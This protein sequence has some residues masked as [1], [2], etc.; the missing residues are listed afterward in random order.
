MLNLQNDVESL[1]EL[2]EKKQRVVLYGAGASARL[3]LKSYRDIFP[4]NSLEFIIDGSQ[5][6]DG[7]YCVVDDD[8]KIRIISLKHFCD[9]YSG[10]TELFT[11]LLTPYYSLFII[12][13]LDRLEALDG[14]EAYV[15]SFIVNR[16]PP[17][18]FSFKCLDKPVIPRILHYFWL[19]GSRMPQE[20]EKHMESWRR[21]CPDYEIMR[22]DESNYDFSKYRYAREALESRQY[23]YATDVARKD[24]L[25]RYGGI[26]FD[27]DVELLR[28]V[29]DLLYQEAFIGIDDGGQLNSGS[30][31]GCVKHSRIVGEM[32]EL[33]R[34]KA[35]INED[36]SFNLHYNTLYETEL[37]I[38]KGY[39]IKNEYQRI[40]G[41][42]CFPREVF[43][44]RGTVGVY[45][46]YT[47]R[48]VSDHK[49]NPY[50]Q[51]PIK[52]VRDRL[53][54]GQI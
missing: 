1:K 7:R 48:T 32:L 36:G 51:S 33:Y 5:A 21:F 10:K 6:M 44:P 16:T 49:I 29:D 41:M 20:Y 22:W 17:G 30:G 19:G 12:K 31:L 47:D 35:F 45:D 38:G 14:V 8:L 43:M 37:M 15:H 9:L 42:S 4:E 25:Y 28:P 2:F 54:R 40:Q 26:Y 11:L 34:D 53:Y 52:A 23:M 18:R 46:N 50:D 3:L 27:T 39:K 13:E 24:I